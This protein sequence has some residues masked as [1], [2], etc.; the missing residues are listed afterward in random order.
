L[1]RRAIFYY[2]M[3]AM[4]LGAQFLTSGFLAEQVTAFQMQEAST[5]SIKQRIG[6][7]GKTNSKAE[8]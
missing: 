8:S 5:Y 3:G 7:S 2:S 1:H 4:L 6:N